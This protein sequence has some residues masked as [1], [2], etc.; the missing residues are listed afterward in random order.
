LQTGEVLLEKFDTEESLAEKMGL[1]SSVLVKDRNEQTDR[2]LLRIKEDFDLTSE[3]FVQFLQ[4][5]RRAFPR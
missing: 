1:P 3:A 5:A 2:V 4:E